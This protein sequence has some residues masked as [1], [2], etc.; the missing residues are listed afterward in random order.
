MRKKKK[1]MIHL[2]WLSLK[3]VVRTS[4]AVLKREARCSKARSKKCIKLSPL[5]VRLESESLIEKQ[6]EC[7]CR[8]EC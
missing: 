5:L 8:Q 2:S 6:D 1:W 7:T 3:Q 4:I